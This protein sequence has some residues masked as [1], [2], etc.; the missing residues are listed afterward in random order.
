MNIGI[1]P[2]R[3]GSKRIPGKNI[4]LFMGQPM[5]TYSISAALQSGVFDELMVSTDDEAIAK[6]A[7]A[8]GAK[9]PFMRSTKNAGDD[10]S[11]VD[12]ITEVL[13]C[14]KKE[15]LK[16]DSIGLIYATAPFITPE[17][18]QKGYHLYQKSKADGVLS[19]AKFDS[20]IERAFEIYNGK[21]RMLWPEYMF[22]SSNSLPPRYYDSG[23]FYFL[24]TKSFLAQKRV[25]LDNMVPLE[26]PLTHVQ[27]INTDED[28]TIA[29]MKY[30]ILHHV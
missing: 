20:P 4:K 22:R 27:D 6:V 3:G 18:L 17:I 26:L 1:I 13:T 25:F 11:I 24:N 2:A 7:R 9:V 10:A 16:F 8:S 5:I 19:V 29:E 28:W 21:V 30:K 12:V 23:Q 15:N 14:Y